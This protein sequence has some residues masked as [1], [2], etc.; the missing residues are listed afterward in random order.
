MLHK[1]AVQLQMRMKNNGVESAPSVDVIVYALKIVTNTL[2]IVVISLLV[3][4]LTGELGRTLLLLIVFAVVRFLSGGY[5]LKSGWWCIL[6]SSATMSI[7]P[8]IRMSEM[9]IYILTGIAL[10]FFLLLAPANYD[11]YARI[12][13]RHLPLL[14]LLSS[15]IVASNF[16]IGSDV[17]ALAFMTQALLLPFKE[18]GGEG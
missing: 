3:G 7:I 18:G 2:S 6:V 4:L 5:H 11:K 15:A 17:L 14:K 9:W 16:L 12:E 1:A 13:A 8:H 10:V